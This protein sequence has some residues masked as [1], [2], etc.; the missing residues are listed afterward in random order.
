VAGRDCLAVPCP[1]L[2]FA[3]SEGVEACDLA[4]NQ[5]DVGRN[6]AHLFEGSFL[7]PRGRSFPGST[8]RS[9]EAFYRADEREISAQL[10]CGEMNPLVLD[11][12]GT[13]LATMHCWTLFRLLNF[14]Q[15]WAGERP[16]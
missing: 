15:R 16:P 8:R 14:L 2:D 7:Q 3:H 4:I 5:K 10:L 11:Q 12:G 9:I 13:R 1:Q 6:V